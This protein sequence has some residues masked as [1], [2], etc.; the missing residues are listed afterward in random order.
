M[1]LYLEMFIVVYHNKSS[2]T[3]TI[4]F[5]LVCTALIKKKKNKH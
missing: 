1:K 3:Y 5:V 2:F 4:D